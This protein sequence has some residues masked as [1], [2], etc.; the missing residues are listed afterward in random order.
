MDV[1]LGGKNIIVIIVWIINNILV[2]NLIIN[3][4]NFR[5]YNNFERYLYLINLLY[6]V[7][8]WGFKIINFY[9]W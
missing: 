1:S 9:W 6:F 8:M 5:F 2:F 4:F 7:M 3:N